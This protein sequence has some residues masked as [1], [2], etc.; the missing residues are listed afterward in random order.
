MRNKLICFVLIGVLGLSFQSCASKNNN[1][2]KD[3]EVEEGK[4]DAFTLGDFY[5]DNPSLENKVEEVFGSLT[6]MQRVGQMI[7]QA[8]GRLGKPDKEI[9]RL[10]RE[11]KI[12]GILLLNGSVDGFKQKVFRFDSLTNA[13]GLLPLVYSADAEPS[14]INRKIE[15]SPTVP[16]TIELKSEA[17]NKKIAAIIS[18]Q[19]KEIGILH[20]YAP[21][22]DISPDNAAIKN[23]SYGYSEDSVKMLAMAF[24]NE[25]QQHG[26]A[27]TI[28]HFPGH[29]LVHG[30]THS[31][32]VFIDGEMK[33]TALYKPFIENGVISVMV[34]HI[35]VKN[36]AAYNTDGMPAS[37]S[38][39]IVTQLLRKEMGF[40]GII[41][42]DAMNMGALNKIPNADFL[43]VLAGNDMILMPGDEDQIID[44]ALSKMKEDEAFRERIYDSVKRIIRLK[45]CLGEI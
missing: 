27:A 24:V 14:L 2:E 12:G 13:H 19:L 22:L 6:D 17:D 10:I 29:G 23:R 18:S 31:N 15:G 38:E 4:V 26:V 21:V 20:N 1:G 42:T 25:S 9:D 5:S 44:Q 39:K 8:A 3:K 34:G 43:A 16:K 28:K 11:N 33:E 40:R 45:I 36:N 41:V 30:D 35:A 7:V 32:L 37:C